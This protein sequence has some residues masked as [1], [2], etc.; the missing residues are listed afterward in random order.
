MKIFKKK[1]KLILLKCPECQS[2]FKIYDDNDDNDDYYSHIHCHNCG[3]PI[4]IY[5]ND[6][7]IEEHE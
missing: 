4:Y 6:N 1:I 3:S 2:I 5:L 7:D